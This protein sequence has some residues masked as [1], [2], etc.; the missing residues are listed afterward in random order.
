MSDV[1]PLVPVLELIRGGRIVRVFEINGPD[2]HIGRTP[3]SEVKF[4]ETK[5]SRNHAR[6]ERRPDGSCYLVDLNSQNKTYL[7]DAGWNRST[8]S[9]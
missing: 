7:D 5:V 1:Q 3:G 2:L 8:R 9:A 6:I 4:N